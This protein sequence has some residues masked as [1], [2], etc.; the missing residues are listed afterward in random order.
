MNNILIVIF[1]TGV[2]HGIMI[3]A[4]LIAIIECIMALI[5]LRHEGE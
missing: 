1:L 4:S 2:K 3:S 5:M